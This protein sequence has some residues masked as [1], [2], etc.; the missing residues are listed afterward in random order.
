MDGDGP[1]DPL[2]PQDGREQQQ[3]QEMKSA[4]RKLVALGVSMAGVVTVDMLLC[5]Y[6]CSGGFKAQ[7][8]GGSKMGETLSRHEVGHPVRVASLVA[9]TQ[10]RQICTH[11]KRR[12]RYK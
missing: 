4:S 11:A 12:S 1:A 2:L 6:S 10:L 8:L 7:P 3:Q 5:S 9:F